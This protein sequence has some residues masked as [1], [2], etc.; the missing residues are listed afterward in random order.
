MIPFG[1]VVNR[2]SKTQ[3]ILTANSSDIE[4]ILHAAIKRKR[5]LFPDWDILYLA[6]PKHDAEERQTTLDY[7]QQIIS[8]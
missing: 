2:F 5:Q 8:K 6:I 1:I 4:V 3:T 7:L